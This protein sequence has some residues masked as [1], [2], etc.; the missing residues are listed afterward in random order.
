MVQKQ[1]R[2]SNYCNVKF[3]FYTCAFNMGKYCSL[4]SQT[5]AELHD[6][7]IQGV[8]KSS[9]FQIYQSTSI[10]GQATPPAPFCFLLLKKK[11]M[12]IR[13][14]GL[15]DVHESWLFCRQSVLTW[16]TTLSTPDFEGKQ[17]F[18]MFPPTRIRSL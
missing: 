11:H 7:G 2:F 13:A 17:E 12:R 16:M 15:C 3:L 14:D 4:I 8:Q 5:T 18:Q 9:V 10:G 6:G 1:S